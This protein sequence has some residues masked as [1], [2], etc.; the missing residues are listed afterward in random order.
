[1]AQI[2][3]LIDKFNRLDN[4]SEILVRASIYRCACN[5]ANHQTRSLIVDKGWKPKRRPMLIILLEIQKLDVVLPGS[6]NN[7]GVCP[8]HP[9]ILKT[10]STMHRP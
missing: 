10:V 8:P 6:R 9:I 2:D 3:L 5:M 7:D 4:I 1:V